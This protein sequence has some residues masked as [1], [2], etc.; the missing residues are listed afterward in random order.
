MQNRTE[1]ILVN[2]IINEKKNRGIPG[3]PSK[4]KTLEAERHP[5]FLTSPNYPGNYG[6]YQQRLSCSWLIKASSEYEDVVIQ[7]QVHNSSIEPATGCWRDSVEIVDGPKDFF[8][9]LISWCGSTWPKATITSTAS[10]VLVKFGTDFKK[11]DYY[12]FML[13]YWVAKRPIFIANPIEWTTLNYSLLSI[14]LAFM[15]GITT[16]LIGLYMKREF[17]PHITILLSELTT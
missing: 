16:W 12:G 17:I 4:T 1:Q 9:P 6:V 11:N 14:G 8:R 15:F 5:K 7:L 3:C 13:S 10:E 2:E